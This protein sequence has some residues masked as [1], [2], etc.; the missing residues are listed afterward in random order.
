[1]PERDKIGSITHPR[2]QNKQFCFLTFTLSGLFSEI[3]IVML[4]ILVQRSVGR[5]ARAKLQA[6]AGCGKKTGRFGA[7]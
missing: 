6:D 1:M 3:D 4:E 7:H 5:P 2:S